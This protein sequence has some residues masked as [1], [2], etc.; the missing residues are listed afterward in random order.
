MGATGV[1]DVIARKSGLHD[2]IE[3][4]AVEC[5]HKRNGS[6][7]NKE[8]HVKVSDHA[9][10]PPGPVLSCRQKGEAVHIARRTPGVWTVDNQLAVEWC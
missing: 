4:A 8:I 6:L 5:A 7:V 3:T 1:T 10:T 2:A 9:A